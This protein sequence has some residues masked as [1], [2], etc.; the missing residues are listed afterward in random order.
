MLYPYISTNKWIKLYFAHYT[1]N[2]LISP[3]WY[4]KVAMNIISSYHKLNLTFAI[5]NVQFIICSN[6]NEP[7]WQ[8]SFKKIVRNQF[9][10]FVLRNQRTIRTV[11]QPINPIEHLAKLTDIDWYARMMTC[12]IV[13]QGDRI[14]A[15]M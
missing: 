8:S 11:L 2:F 6:L 13:G 15:K 9:R 14:H 1:S 5:Y 3:K 7:K 10:I 12:R 4:R